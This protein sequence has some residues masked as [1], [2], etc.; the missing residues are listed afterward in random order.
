MKAIF[1]FQSEKEGTFESP[2][3]PP[4]GFLISASVVPHCGKTR[5][6][7]KRKIE[8]RNGKKGAWSSL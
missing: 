7:N 1:P 4:G 3:L 2:E 5:K 8:R 6:V